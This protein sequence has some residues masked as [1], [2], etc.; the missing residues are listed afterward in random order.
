MIL[1]IQIIVTH[2]TLYRK[3]KDKKFNILCQYLHNQSNIELVAPSNFYRLFEKKYKPYG[4]RQVLRRGIPPS[5]EEQNLVNGLK[6]IIKIVNVADPEGEYKKYYEMALFVKLCDQIQAFGIWD[7]Y[8][9]VFKSDVVS[10]SEK[11][12]DIPYISTSEIL[13]Y[14]GKDQDFL[15]W[16]R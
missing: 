3:M 4:A 1:M 2:E 6:K 11:L 15:L 9:F 7:D 16:D 12:E 13:R 10:D 5:T 8:E 14:I